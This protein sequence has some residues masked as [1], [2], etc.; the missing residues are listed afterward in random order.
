MSKSRTTVLT[1]APRGIMNTLRVK[2]PSL[3]DAERIK[4]IYDTSPISGGSDLLSM[5][6]K[7]KMFKNVIKKQKS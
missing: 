3:T 5:L 4:V 1:R 6:R 7:D 2:L